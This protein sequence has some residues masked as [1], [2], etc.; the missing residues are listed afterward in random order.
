MIQGRNIELLPNRR[1]IQAWRAKT[2]ADGVYSIVRFE[3]KE[4][5]AE[6]KLVFEHCGFPERSEG[7]S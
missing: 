3:L 5:G 6:T 1:I 4:Q 2:W 7:S